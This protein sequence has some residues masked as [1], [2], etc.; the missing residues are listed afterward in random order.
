MAGVLA[1]SDG[2]VQ[3]TSRDRRVSLVLPRGHLELDVD[4]ARDLDV[5]VSTAEARIQ[6]EGTRFSVTRGPSGT[7]V[8]VERGRVAVTCTGRH[9][10]QL[11]GAGGRVTCLRSVG[12]GLG[13]A[14]GQRR[15]GAMARSLETTRDA[16][17][18]PGGTPATRASLLAL[19]TELLLALDR[20]DEA[21][22]VA[23]TTLAGEAGLHRDTWTRAVLAAPGCPQAEP[24]LSRLHDVGDAKASAHLARCLAPTAPDLAAEVLDEALARDPDPETR[25]RLERLSGAGAAA[26][27]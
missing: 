4:P 7:T 9:A 26:R 10:V 27:R 15:V 16:Q 8:A 11:L 20:R 19:E 13:L 17:A 3:G 22:A 25:R 18:L 1:W 12:L 6:V 2:P 23:E 5:T 21:L 24:F 14:L